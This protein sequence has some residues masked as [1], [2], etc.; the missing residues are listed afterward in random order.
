MRNLRLV[1]VIAVLAVLAAACGGTAT[2]ATTAAPA[3][4]AAAPETTASGPV[5]V[6]LTA[7]EM[8][9]ASDLTTFKVGVPY[10]FEVTNTGKIAHE[11]M[12]VEPTDLADMEAIDE[13]A[14][15]MVE[16]DDLGP[17]ATESFEYT[18]TQDDLAGPLELACH[19]PGHY[20]A[21]MKLAIT[22]EA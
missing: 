18:F 17:G 22:V 8:T 7:D 20:E 9:I 21:G 12:L 6:H 15:G 3:T 19:V 11:V 1:A 13:L 5:V 4:T 16:E 14:L 2:T 10:E